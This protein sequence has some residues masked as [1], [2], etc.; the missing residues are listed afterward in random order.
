MGA[1]CEIADSCQEEGNAIARLSMNI[2]VCIES[3]YTCSKYFI[4]VVVDTTNNTK[5]TFYIQE[6]EAL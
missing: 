2:M 4:T 5:A 6:S 3:V 1:D